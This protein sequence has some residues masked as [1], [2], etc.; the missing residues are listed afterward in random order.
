MQL[1]EAV[2]YAP[3]VKCLSGED[4]FDSMCEVVQPAAIC[5]DLPY[6]LLSETD[7]ELLK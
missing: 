1:L 5:S 3:C 6:Y 7:L 4:F 2:S